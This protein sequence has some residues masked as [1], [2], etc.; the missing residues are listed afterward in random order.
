MT[1]NLTPR[2]CLGYRTPLEAFTSELGRNL[3]T[4]FA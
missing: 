1:L 2:K 3:E 4:R